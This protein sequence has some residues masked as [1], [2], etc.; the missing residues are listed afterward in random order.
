[1]TGPPR[2][3]ARAG[4]FRLLTL[5]S[6]SILAAEA[7][8]ML[9]LQPLRDQ[10]GN[11][12][13]LADSLLLTAVLFP[14]LYFL[15]FNRLVPKNEALAAAQRELS[16][17]YEDL[18]RQFEERTKETERA[19][20]DLEISL[21]RFADIAESAGDWI[22]EMDS[23]LRFSYMSPRFFELFSI[24]PEE[25]IGKTR[26][27]FAGIS[28]HDEH[29]RR[30]LDDLANHRPFRDFAYATTQ[31]D[32]RPRHIL[33]RGKPVFDADGVFK[34]Y[35]G[36]GTDK[37]AEVEAHKALEERE[38]QFRNLVEGSI[39]GV[40]V[41]SGGKPLFANQALAD[42]L[43]YRDP[44][45]ILSLERTESLIAP[46]ELE[47]LTG[48][49]IAREKGE[50]APEVYEAQ[51]L[52]KDGSKIW[53]EFRVTQIDWRGTAAMQCVVIDITERKN[54]AEAL[55]QQNKRFNAALENMSQALCMFDDEHRL[56][57]WNQRYA[58]LYCVSP[59]RL[60]PGIS[61]REILEY[62][63]GGGIYVEEGQEG[64]IKETI[65]DIRRGTYG[66]KMRRL[67]DGRTI[68]V[69]YHPMSGGGWLATHE[70]I[71][72]RIKA[73]EALR[74]SQELFSKA[75]HASPAPFAITDPED[76]AFYD[77]NEAW[78][79]VFGYTR[80]EVMAHTALEIG[81]W[82]EL[83]QRQR[84]VKLLRTEGSARNF[85]AK[86]RTK[87]NGE[88]D[89]LVS[90]VY[91]ELGGQPRL[92]A[93]SYDI[94]ALK[95]AERALQQQN[96]RFNAAL[97]NMSQ[98][99]CMFDGEQR[100][101]VCNNRYAAMYGL[102]PEQ[103]QRGTLFRQI[104]EQR[105]A[106]GIYA[107]DAPEDYIQERCAAVLECQ[108]TSKIQELS[109]GRAIAIS[110]QPLAGGGWLATHQDITDYRRIEDRLAY[111]AHHDALTDLPNRI[112][113]HERL[114]ES[115]NGANR[116]DGFALLYLDL[117]GFK[118]I[119]DTLGHSAG[120]NLLKVVSGR[121]RDCVAETDMVARLGGDE[122]AIIQ[123][124]NARASDAAELAGRICNA[125]RA[126]IDLGHHEVVVGTSIGIAFAPE[127]GA[128]PDQLLKNADMALHHAKSTSR[129]T[130]RCFEPEMEAHTRDRQTLGLDLRRALS[131]D[132]FELYYQPIFNLKENKVSGFEALLRWH[133][134]DRGFMSPAEF[135]PVAEEIGLI[136]ELG[137]WVLS[138]AC[139]EA[140][141]W[142]DDIN[143]AVNVSP[144]QFK[145]GNLLEVVRNALSASNLCPSRLELEITESV[146]L[147]DDR[148]TLAMLHQLQQLGARISM[149]DF[150][151]GYSSL[152]YLRRFP[153]DKIKIDASFVG[154]LSEGADDIGIVHAVVSLASRL[155]VAT[156]A[157]GVETEEQL[158][159]V[160]VEGCT[161]AQ[162]FLFSRPL[163]A[164]DVSHFL[165]Q[166]IKKA[167]SAA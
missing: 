138:T 103:V 38:T 86:F 158:E 165:P 105:I 54:A 155:G 137:E 30:H 111:L 94:T 33:V 149:D 140:A 109:D 2:R 100:L 128:N 51:G 83:D 163:P 52:R 46:E 4:T 74:Q 80:D 67:N 145:R 141:N 64:F 14:I 22:W 59:E 95:I 160:K 162:G 37:T 115:L 27:E 96:E 13:V 24:A 92:F 129:G 124:A 16:A 31:A 167:V 117:D 114:E 99:L 81:L 23:N 139:A 19:K 62:R 44:E 63:A 32:G 85:H 42:I 161:E 43:G 143:I 104:V 77:V 97:E 121:L 79:S 21:E 123:A 91:V 142:P 10:Y 156:T 119:N 116:G 36:T 58:S 55:Q 20:R 93:V 68:E 66:K 112:L 61:L 89:F 106:N 75:F 113:L 6:V 39:Q 125:I 72:E 50:H 118:G 60:K 71:T 131:R 9:F 122:F 84:F 150:G 126:P 41:H 34:G 76:G 35:W 159:I 45:E 70:D 132:E 47:R 48:Y 146:V 18:E 127:D 5:L 147:Q 11:L 15:V 166:R 154:D 164:K 135:I 17:A 26:D 82:A 133:R 56:V 88:R 120:D 108:P 98:G 49:R 101:V 78:I 40:F 153:F 3:T 107:G 90:G 29:W 69:T 7:V 53:L 151:T 57:V 134:P 152:S 102:S 136:N 110:H 148:A 1:M 8:I 65:N 25:F 12:A 144:V 73:D 87:S 130:H 28:T 157:E